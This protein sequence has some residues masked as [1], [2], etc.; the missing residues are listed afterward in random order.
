MAEELNELLDTAVYKEIVSQ[1]LYIAGQNK[2][3]DPGAKLLMKEL[4]EEELR[5]SQMLKEFKEKDWKVGQ[6]H[7]E[8]VLDRR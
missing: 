5:H 1:A 6:W 3:D 4:P 8:K 7:K 2:T